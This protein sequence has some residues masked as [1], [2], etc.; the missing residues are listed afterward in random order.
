MAIGD[1]VA[2]KN[3]ASSLSDLTDAM[4][5]SDMAEDATDAASSASVSG[6][7]NPRVTFTVGESEYTL[8]TQTLLLYGIVIAD[9]LLLYIALRV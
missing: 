9:A 1:V 6:V 5:N 3:G 2:Q 8:T 7:E 4:E